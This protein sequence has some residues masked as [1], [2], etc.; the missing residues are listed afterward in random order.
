[1]CS[2]K[3]GEGARG[4]W[5]RPA[6]RESQAS[7][8][9]AFDIRVEYRLV[10]GFAIL[11]AVCCLLAQAPDFETHYRN[12]LLALNQNDLRAAQSHL[13][14]ARKLAPRNARVWMALAQ[15]YWKLGRRVPSEKAVAQAEKLGVEDPAVLRSLALYYAGREEPAKAAGFEAR[16]AALA[17]EDAAAVARAMS[18]YLQAGQPKPAIDLGLKAPGWERR[19]EIRNLLGQAYHADGQ[20]LKAIPELQEA[21][22]LS[23]YE[24][25]H[26][27]DLARVLLEHHN[28]EAAIRVLE[29]SK[30]IFAKSAQLELALGVAHY[31]QGH[32]QEA[33]E[34]FLRTVTLEPSA[35]QPYVFL[36]RLLERAG[37]QLPEV[38]RRFEA[39]E[40][41]E[42]KNHLGWFLHAKALNQ[43]MESPELSEKLLRR[44]IGLS[45]AFW[46]SHYELARVL[47]Q[48]GRLAEAAQAYRRSA[49][50]DSQA[51]APH[52]RV[53]MVL[54][55]L[56]R[57]EEAK[58]ERDLYQKLAAAERAVVQERLSKTVRLDLVVR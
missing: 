11:V 32:Y 9:P 29:A 41:S 39:L 52:Y 42:P 33:V 3:I 53:A 2:K 57:P 21:V 49:Q 44:A 38:I 6:A 16:Y 10:A 26:H 12:G 40:R 28:F 4:D 51:P 56:G 13:E 36:G 5:Q 54:L 24:E 45:G 58:A 19:A 46:E 14:A 47:E 37:D 34:S 55:K 8:I 43:R 20:Y 35:E 27:F 1:M 18:L 48:Q 50:L 22:R 31:G 15:T 17:P 30:Q 7:V 25:A 23:P